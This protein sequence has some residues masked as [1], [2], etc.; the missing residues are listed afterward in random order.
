MAIIIYIC[1]MKR[2]QIL[3]E[4][5]SLCYNEAVN[6]YLIL[7]EHCE[8]EVTSVNIVE[9]PAALNFYDETFYYYPF[10]WN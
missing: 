5:F 2:K 8:G 6:R 9:I 10:L 3:Q 1:T 4:S 7:I